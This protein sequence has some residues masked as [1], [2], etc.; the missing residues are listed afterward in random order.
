MLPNALGLLLQLGELL[1]NQLLRISNR[2]LRLILRIRGG[3]LGFALDANSFSFIVFADT[4][5][6]SLQSSLSFILN[7][8]R[9]CFTT[10]ALIFSFLFCSSNVAFLL[11]DSIFKFFVG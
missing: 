7:S 8:E 6:L 10:L 11:G 9:F 3:C 5:H 2:G 4:L 1:I